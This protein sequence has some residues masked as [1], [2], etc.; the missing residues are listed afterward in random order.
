MTCKPGLWAIIAIL[1]LSACHKNDNAEPNVTLKGILPILA[2][3]VTP[4]S[5]YP[6]TDTF[7]GQYNEVNTDLA[8]YNYSG[9]S[10]ITVTH[11]SSDSIII[12]SPSIGVPHGTI[13][14][15]DEAYYPTKTN[16]ANTY[17]FTT[18]WYSDRLDSY[19]C[20]F[21]NDSVHCSIS[22]T[23][24]SAARTGIYNGSYTGYKK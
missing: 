6:Y 15:S 2:Y 23:T 18:Q 4:T 16:S 1:V 14:Y 10:T 20:V 7:Y 13:S 12:A 17:S 11:L 5:I 21:A 9:Y 19:T 8:P 3:T 24:A 22:Q